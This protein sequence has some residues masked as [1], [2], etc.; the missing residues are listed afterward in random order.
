MQS[1]YKLPN[2]P[3]GDI[4]RFDYDAARKADPGFGGTYFVDG[5]EITLRLG[6]E[7]VVAQRAAKGD[8]TIRGT[9]Y[10]HQTLK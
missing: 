6:N 2:A 4:S 8:I 5:N 1:G 7:T 10:Q 9:T 3:N